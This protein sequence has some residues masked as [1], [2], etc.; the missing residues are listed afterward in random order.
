MGPG[1]DRAL[2]FIILVHKKT[3]LKKLGENYS[4]RTSA[5]NPRIGLPSGKY[6]SG[7][8]SDVI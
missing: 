5:S 7:D 4:P 1:A 8:R 6:V 3:N 2:F